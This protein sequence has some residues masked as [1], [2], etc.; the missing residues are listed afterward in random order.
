MSD[1]TAKAIS[2][3]GI[4][5]DINTPDAML[6]NQPIST[7]KVVSA[8]RVKGKCPD[9]RVQNSVFLNNVHLI[10]LKTV[11]KSTLRYTTHGVVSPTL[12]LVLSQLVSNCYQTQM[13]QIKSW[14]NFHYTIHEIVR[15]TSKLNFSVL[16]RFTNQC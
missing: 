5:M 2:P 15:S 14:E 1:P 6:D 13:L 8:P 11:T 7:A 9:T 3:Q 4:S 16:S 12:T 10:C